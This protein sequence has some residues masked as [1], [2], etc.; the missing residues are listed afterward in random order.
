MGEPVV[1]YASAV[2]VRIAVP[3]V[4]A[5]AAA[6]LLAAA[7]GARPERSACT[8]GVVKFG[9][10]TARVFCGP[11]KATLRVGGKTI[12]FAGGSCERT[13]RYVALNVGTV[14]LGQTTKRKPDYFGLTVGAYPSASAKPAGHDGAYTGGV[15]A[16]EKGGK[17]YLVRG[18]TARITLAGGRTRGTFKSTLLFGGGA[19][20]GTFSCR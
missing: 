11:A 7:S 16:A 3:L 18:D 14:V 5:A 1:P 20:S 15:V 9:G 17:P 6:L 19:V 2:P 10:V 12:S 4:A 13:S 8:S